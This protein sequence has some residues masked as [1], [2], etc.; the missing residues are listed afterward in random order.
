M[1]I[2][3]DIISDEME[4]KEHIQRLTSQSPVDGEEFCSELLRE[5]AQKL[6]L[7]RAASSAYARCLCAFLLDKKNKS[8]L[9]EIIKNNRVIREAFFGQM[10][11][12]KYSIIFVL[13]RVLKLN[14]NELTREVLTLLSNN[15]FRDD[16]AKSYSDRWSLKFIID[17]VRNAPVDYLNLSAKSI[18]MLNEFGGE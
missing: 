17:E 6:S 9:T 5:N 4:I 8:R 15:P 1:D 18:E 12:Y 10:N 16:S 14:D 7:S 2:C 11:T 3:G 13:K